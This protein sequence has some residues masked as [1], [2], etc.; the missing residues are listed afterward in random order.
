M[1]E[2][3]SDELERWLAGGSSKTLGGLIA[4]FGARSFA[5]VFVLLLG[6]SAL[7]LPTGGATHVF[8]VIAMLLA[9]QMI[10]GV[11]EIWLPRRW[12]AIELAGERRQRFIA[13]LIRLMRWL[14]RHS[15]PRLHCS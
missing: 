14:E 12:R 3:V 2:A 4:T 11:R 1:R 6:V 5:L 7:P 15:K 8:E 10:V 9:L 13:T